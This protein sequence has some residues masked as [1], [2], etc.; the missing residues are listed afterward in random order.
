[1]MR[2]ENLKHK[3]IYFVEYNG[4]ILKF[5]GFDNLEAW[6]KKRKEGETWILNIVSAYSKDTKKED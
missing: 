4:E 6:I 2:W 1:M 5:K 3:Q